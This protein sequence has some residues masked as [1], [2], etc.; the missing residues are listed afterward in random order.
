[1][2]PLPAGAIRS[3]VL[4]MRAPMKYRA[5]TLILSVLILGGLRFWTSAVAAEVPTNSPGSR[6]FGEARLAYSAKAISGEVGEIP[7]QEV[8]IK[9]DIVFCKPS[10]QPAG[11]LIADF[12]G[13]DMVMKSSTLEWLVVSAKQVELK[14]SCFLDDADG[15]TFQMKVEQSETGKRRIRLK[16]WETAM[17]SHVV[18][19]SQPDESW[20][21]PF[22]TT[23]EVL[24]G[25]LRIG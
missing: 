8:S 6:F 4:K 14:G 12:R 16:V 1:M 25:D 19:D 24:S 2:N 15:F 3:F 11:T 20:S 17:P 10:A 5:S 22:K 7:G 9:A 13:A 23:G 21:A 18:F